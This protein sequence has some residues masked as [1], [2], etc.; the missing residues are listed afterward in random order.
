MRPRSSVAVMQTHGQD[1]ETYPVTPAMGRTGRAHRGY[2]YRGAPRPD[3][4]ASR[5]AELLERLADQRRMISLR[6]SRLRALSLELNKQVAQ[7]VCDGVKAAS[8]ARAARLP[9]ATVRGIGAGRDE[10][11]PSGQSPEFHLG[12]IAAL[13]AEVASV[14]A[15]RAAVEQARTQALATARKLRLL[16]DY[17]LASASGLKPEEIARMTRGVG[18]A[19]A[20]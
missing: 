11:Y 3:P 6:S 5:L 1:S 7:A 2:R 10:F 16:D 17:Q 18:T 15:A 13:A 14:E 9:A 8:I 12:R 19:Q 20:S 4:A